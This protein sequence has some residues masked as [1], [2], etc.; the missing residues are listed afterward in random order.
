MAKQTVNIGAAANDGT[1]DPIRDAFD[2]LN[3]NFDEVS[4]ISSYTIPSKMNAAEDNIN[5]DQPEETP[6]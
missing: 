2:K 5:F 3:Q 4:S 1:G 6:F